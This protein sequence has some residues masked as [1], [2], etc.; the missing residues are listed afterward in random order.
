MQ[1]PPIGQYP[2]PPNRVFNEYSSPPQ[3]NSG[4][5]VGNYGAFGSTG[6]FYPPPPPPSAYDYYNPYSMPPPPP[7][8]GY[9]YPPGPV[10]FFAFFAFF[11][12]VTYILEATNVICSKILNIILYV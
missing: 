6:G 11:L 4:Q 10:F 8:L 3:P 2:P 5:N 12:F 7:P 9:N 1:R